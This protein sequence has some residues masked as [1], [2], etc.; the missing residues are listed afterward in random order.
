MIDREKMIAAA[1]VKEKINPIVGEL[2]HSGWQLGSENAPR[3]MDWK[4]LEQGTAKIKALIEECIDAVLKLADEA[5][6]NIPSGSLDSEDW[7]ETRALQDKVERFRKR[8]AK[9]KEGL[10]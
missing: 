2:F 3:S 5:I 4:Y 1:F 10:K 7:K 9:I 6:E 8:A